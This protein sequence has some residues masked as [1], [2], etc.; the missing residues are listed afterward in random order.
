MTTEATQNTQTPVDPELPIKDEP[1]TGSSVLDWLLDQLKSFALTIWDMFTD[2]LLFIVDIFMD[3]GMSILNG[4]SYALEL[5]DLS[6]YISGM[7]SEVMFIF[8]ATG[9]GTAV[10][11]VMT[12][13]AV[14][15]FMQLIPFVRLGS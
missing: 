10:G 11:M 9:L 15:L 1:S 4:F 6:Q 12:A 14:R 13:G 2:L 8:D 7:P 3:L 5:M